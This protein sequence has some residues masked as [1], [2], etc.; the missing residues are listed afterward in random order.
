MRNSLLN[1]K[2][3]NH[4]FKHYENKFIN[5]PKVLHYPN[6]GFLSKHVDFNYNNDSNFIVV[7]SKK[8]DHY[9]KGGLSYEIKKNISILRNF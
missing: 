6:G 7:A 3:K 2:S 9:H 8:G 4:I 5:I 1:I